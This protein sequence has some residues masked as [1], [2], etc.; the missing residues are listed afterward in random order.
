M[1]VV[2]LLLIVC[3]LFPREAKS[4][5]QDPQN[6]QSLSVVDA[7]RRSREL[8]KNAGPP[9]RV[10]TNDDL[11]AEQT[12][13]TRESFNAGAL[14]TPQTESSNASAVGTAQ[15]P[16]H[17]STSS[18]KESISKSDESEEA[19]VEDA[20]IAILKDQLASA[21]NAL[22]WQRRQF[23]LDQNT[24]YSNPAYT[25]THAGKAELD[26]AQSQIDQIQQDV[27]GLKEP[28]ANLVWRQ[29]RRM[30]TGA[31]DNGSPGENYRSVPPSALV[32]PQ[33]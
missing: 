11:D 24:I 28:L 16:N 31:P 32:L 5:P 30:Q 8:K 23:F 20:E 29:W 7:A 17:D 4:E 19:A 12:K 33:P 22:T 14:T 13:R 10:F 21:Q 2:F 27:D 6:H 26:S 18:N 3:T 9:A 1:F 25:T 15:A